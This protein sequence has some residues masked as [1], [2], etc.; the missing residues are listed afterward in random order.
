MRSAAE[1]DRLLKM[2][3]VGAARIE[4]HEAIGR[5]DEPAAPAGHVV[6]AYVTA[7]IVEITVGGRPSRRCGSGGMV[8][9]PA[10]LPSSFHGVADGEP[11]GLILG[12]A[13]IRLS[14]AAMLDRVRVPIFADLRGTPLV[15]PAM[16]E[17]AR[18]AAAPDAAMPAG[19]LSAALMKTCILVLLRD[20]FGRPGIDLKIIG[21]LADDRLASVIAA[22]LERPGDP[23]SLTSM[24]AR[25][26]LS[27]S[28]FSRLFDEAMGQPPTEFV[29]KTRLYHAA[30]QLRTGTAPV[31][32]VAASVGF[33]SRSHFS[34]AFRDA[35][36][37]DPTAYRQQH[38]APAAAPV[39]QD[40][41]RI[42]IA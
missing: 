23:H 32:A 36:G 39:P 8:L 27:R 1:L 34:R 29:A 14:G 25:A 10:A 3:D 21:A 28:T 26:G 38:A 7:G 24:A 20:F 6:I 18:L 41:R 37:L 15:A 4:R 5:R 35:Y 42:P 33:S 12:L 30:E 2:M 11:P 16:A 19:A 9:V 13:E 31:K 22:V 40:L 17:L